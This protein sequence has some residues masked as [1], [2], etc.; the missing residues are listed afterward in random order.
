[1][2]SFAGQH[3]HPPPPPTSPWVRETQRPLPHPVHEQPGR[4]LCLLPP[5]VPTLSSS[6]AC[7]QPRPWPQESGMRPSPQLMPSPAHPP[8]LP[9]NS[10]LKVGVPKVGFNRCHPV[11]GYTGHCMRVPQCEQSWDM[12]FTGHT[13]RQAEALG[14][15]A[16]HRDG[17]TGPGRAVLRGGQGPPGWRRLEYRIINKYPS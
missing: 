3:C 4:A 7:M 15:G 13:L 12:P 16:G 1:M 8:R 2:S 10:S 5:G 14:R 9:S 17:I 6:Q 11:L